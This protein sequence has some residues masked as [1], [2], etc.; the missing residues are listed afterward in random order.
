MPTS[1]PGKTYGESMKLAWN[2]LDT[3]VYSPNKY[4]TS[5]SGVEGFPARK[6]VLR[7]VC[8]KLFINRAVWPYIYVLLCPG[9]LVMRDVCNVAPRDMG[10]RIAM[11]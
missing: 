7:G 5:V 6:E 4:G 3:S 9:A 2:W 8:D 1:R 11:A 10:R